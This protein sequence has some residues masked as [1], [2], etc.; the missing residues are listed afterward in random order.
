MPGLLRC[1]CSHALQQHGNFDPGWTERYMTQQHG[2]GVGGCWCH[3]FLHP[4]LWTEWP[5]LAKVSA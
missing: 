1:R 3:E 2:C 4:A 5:I